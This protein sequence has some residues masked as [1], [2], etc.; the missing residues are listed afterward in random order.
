MGINVFEGARRIAKLLTLLWVVGCVIYTIY[1]VLD[2]RKQNLETQ[3][4]HKGIAN[5]DDTHYVPSYEEW[6]KAN[7][8]QKPVPSFEEWSAANPEKAAGQKVGEADFA[9]FKAE[10]A[11][12]QDY[13]ELPVFEKPKTVG[14]KTWEHI[15]TGLLWLFGGVAFIWAL[16][17]AIGWIVRGFFGIPSGH[18]FKP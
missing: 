13:P 7:P 11:K 5:A 12:Q 2:L 15:G 3:A 9:A 6:D 17:W 4:K 14:Q 10:K 16:T 8:E 1:D 18:D